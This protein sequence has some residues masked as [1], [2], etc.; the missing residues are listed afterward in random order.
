MLFVYFT[1]LTKIN[2]PTQENAFTLINLICKNNTHN[3]ELNNSYVYIHNNTTNM[4]SYE[5]KPSRKSAHARYHIVLLTAALSMS[6]AI[7]EL[8]IHNNHDGD[9]MKL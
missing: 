8:D 6:K 1:R 7:Y 9:S 5:C 2:P 3:Q 4:L